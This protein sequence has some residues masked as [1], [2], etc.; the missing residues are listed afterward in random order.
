[1]NVTDLVALLG[2]T[3]GS[4]EFRAFLREHGMN[5]LPRVDPTTRVRSS[6]K[7][8]SLEFDLTESYREDHVSG[9]VGDGWLTFR[10]VDVHQGFGGILPLGLS[11]A[12]SKEEVDALLGNSR[13]EDQGD[14][15]QIYYAEPLL[16]IVFYRDERTKIETL[17]FA[18]P[19]RYDVENYGL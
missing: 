14:P 3:S 13:D 1:M 11:H 5:R 16:V 17:R 15:V 2:H 18:R 6:D 8:V 7:L 4:T 9:P 12:M 10:S 19:N